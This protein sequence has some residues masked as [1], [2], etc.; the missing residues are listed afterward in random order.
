MLGL[1]LGFASAVG[2]L[3]LCPCGAA[4]VTGTAAVP[5]VVAADTTTVHFA[6]VGMTCASCAT[7]AQLVLRRVPGVY[8]ARVSLDS[9]H[10][11]VRYDAGRTSPTALIDR[12]REM[13][14]YEARVV[15]AP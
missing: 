10:A 4:P 5:A 11:V 15:E 1:K 9:A 6:I 13:T 12:L 8:E 3:L 7:T 2:A 14:G